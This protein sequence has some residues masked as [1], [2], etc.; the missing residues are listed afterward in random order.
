MRASM[1]NGSKFKKFIKNPGKWLLA[2]YG[3]LLLTVCA[4]VAVAVLWNAAN[5]LIYALYALLLALFI[6][7]LI[8]TVKYGRVYLARKIYSHKFTARLASDYGF[9]TLV[10][11]VI[12]FAINVAYVLFQA[13]MAIINRSLWYGTF[14]VYYALLSA[15]CGVA[16]WADIR[17]NG[18]FIDD[19][20]ARRK[21]KLRAYMW[22]GVFLILLSAA[23]AVA[24]GYMISHDI[25][26]RYAGVTIYVMVA[27]AFYKITIAVINLVK[28][29]KFN[30][31]GVQSLRNIRFTDALVSI[32]AIQT[33]LIAA[34][35]GEDDGSMRIMNAVMAVI[36]CLLTLGLGVYMIIKAA[37]VLKRGEA[38]DG[39]TAA[40]A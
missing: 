14:A 36:V 20:D 10:F 21:A 27:Y 19:A 12:S 22:C 13:V 29:K 33:A 31:Y 1:N 7:C 5:P 6:Y 28:A 26:F 11:S 3:G 40:E 15:V 34:F 23:L 25:S 16:V 4:V 30:D 32:F 24:L 35:G 39:G 17:A 9:R 8:I 38:A 18:R 2:F 37:V